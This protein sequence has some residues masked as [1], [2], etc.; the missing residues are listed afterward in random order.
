MR[1][2]IR[3]DA[4]QNIGSGHVMRCLAFAEE[5]R[6]RGAIIEFITREHQ[7][8][9]NKQINNKGF[10]VHL[11]I[12]QTKQLKN[13]LTGY[14]KLL[15]VRQSIDA[16]QTIQVLI[17][18]EWDWIIVDHYA[19]DYCWERKLKSYSKK[20]MVIDDLANRKHDCD[21][22]LDQNYI[23][24]KC[25]YDHLLSFSTIKLLG[26]KYALIRKDFSENKK[27]KGVN[28]ISKVFVF[29]GGTDVS[30]L[31]QMTIRALSR[32]ELRHLLVD[33]VIGSANPCKS[34]LKI[35]ADKHSNVKIY[36][37]I[38]DMARLMSEAD[39]AIGG[40]G[41]TTWERMTLGLPSLVVTLADNQVASIKDLNRDGYI[42]WIGDINT[43]N[44][45]LIYNAFLKVIKNIS[46]LK[47]QSYNCYSLVKGLGSKI[48]SDFLINGPV[49]EEIFIRKAEISDALLY[50]HW[51]NDPEVRK[52]AFNQ[53]TIEWKEHAIWFEKYLNSHDTILLLAECDLGPI[54][55]VRFDCSGVHCK[56]D[57]SLAK[58]FRGF[59]LGK[60]IL[61]K[62]ILYLSKEHFFTLVAEVKNNNISSI[63]TFEKLGFVK[64]RS[65]SSQKDT[66]I[67]KLEQRMEA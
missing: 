66:C 47:V 11:L 59:G 21:I 30:N 51:V 41:V 45:Q 50:W 10:K 65:R 48:V 19:L 57:F 20:I 27:N 12:T 29:F 18:S 22:L 13:N 31:T 54:G 23:N 61:E 43:V 42:A 62:S 2:A 32:S 7:G 34:E 46:Q 35:E 17:E 14:E 55:Q 8:N 38:D 63:K 39:I 33:V 25:R 24:N 60:K 6:N 53:N 64:S 58:Q 26:P 44:E 28:K 16:D 52:N 15:G 36:I 40:G 4:S 49:L 37:Q 5:L 3:T 56:V 9:L 1:I 67:Y